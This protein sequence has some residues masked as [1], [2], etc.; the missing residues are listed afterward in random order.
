[1][2]NA[3]ETLEDEDSESG[4]EGD[5]Q[6]TEKGGNLYAFGVGASGSFGLRAATLLQFAVNKKDSFLDTEFGLIF[7]IT[8]FS[9]VSTSMSADLTIPLSRTFGNDLESISDLNG[10]AFVAGAEGGPPGATVGGNLS[11]I[12]PS[13]G[14]P[15]VSTL[16]AGP[17]ITAGALGLVEGFAG[18]D[19]TIGGGVTPREVFQQVQ[20]NTV[21]T[22]PVFLP[23]L[24]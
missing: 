13:N 2:K 11:N 7:Q 19:L 8:P 22:V 20:K 3:E 21:I 18:G 12:L 6:E 5:A 1:M 15:T 24:R 14:G 10:I 4:T 23:G 17:G 16:E 9:T